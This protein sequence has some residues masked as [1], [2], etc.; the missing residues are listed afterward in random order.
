MLQLMGAMQGSTAKRKIRS[1]TKEQRKYWRKQRGQGHT[2]E[3]GPQSQ[4]TG[5]HGDS[6]RSESLQGSDLDT[7]YICYG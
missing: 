5:T 1:P 7:L 2:G 4:L 3:H 6:K